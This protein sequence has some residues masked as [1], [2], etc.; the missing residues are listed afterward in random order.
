M[1]LISKISPGTDIPSVI[2]MVVEIPKGRRSKF[3]YDKDLDIFKLDR[4]LYSSSMYPGD[5]GFIPHTLAEDNDPIDVLVMV[6]E[7][8]FPGCLIETRVVGMFLMSDR[9][10]NDYKL[11]GVP[12]RDPL[13]EDYKELEDVPHH[14]LREVEHFF[15]SYKQ[16]EEGADVQSQGWTG[17][18]DAI[19][20]IKKSIDSYTKEKYASSKAI[21]D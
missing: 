1:S 11:L 6:N 9:G 2:N 10:E 20:E 3:E 16:L 15:L 13:F 8:T 18:A 21:R 19:K 4:Y 12:H 17:R 7:A 14:F 5:Y